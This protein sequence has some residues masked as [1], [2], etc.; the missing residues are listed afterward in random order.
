MIKKIICFWAVIIA[1][2]FSIVGCNEIKT[3]KEITDISINEEFLLKKNQTAFLPEENIYIELK[4]IIYSPCPKDVICVWSGLGVKINVSKDNDFKEIFLKGENSK[5]KIYGIQI[6]ILNIEEE[7]VSFKIVKEET[8]EEKRNEKKE[9]VERQYRECLTDAD[10]IP[11]SCCHPNSCV[12]KDKRP[13]CKGI[14]CTMECRPGTLD[15]GQGI[16]RCIDNKCEA[17]FY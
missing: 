2:I 15:C 8:I 9:P 12:S 4:E 3:Q 1:I 17:E 13:D 5:Y 10:C 6:N 7:S 11:A 14:F 16:C